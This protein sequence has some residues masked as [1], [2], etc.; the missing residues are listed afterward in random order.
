MQTFA[1]ADSHGRPRVPPVPPARVDQPLPALEREVLAH[2]SS[3]AAD[4]QGLGQDHL[5][6][7][8]RNEAGPGQAQLRA[9]P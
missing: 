6:L 5:R 1:E 7:P 9:G 4:H 3:G 2:L 8:E